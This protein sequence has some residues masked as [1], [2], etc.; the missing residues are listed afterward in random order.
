MSWDTSSVYVE[1]STYVPGRLELSGRP[2]MPL[3]KPGTLRSSTVGLM[4]EGGFIWVWSSSKYRWV[5]P[6]Q[7]FPLPIVPACF[8]FDYCYSRT[9]ITRTPITRIPR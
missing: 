9:S 4:F 6:P 3:R 2:S 7:R 5:S 8:L 1:K